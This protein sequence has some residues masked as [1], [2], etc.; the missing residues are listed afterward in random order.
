M[1]KPSQ[2]IL[3]AILEKT[4][5]LKISG[6]ASFNSSV[7]FKNIVT[8]LLARGYQHFVLDLADCLTM[9]STFLGVLAGIVLRMEEQSGPKP[10]LELLN[11]N[12]RIVD[13]LEN[14]GVGHLFKVLNE[15]NPCTNLFQPASSSQPAPSKVEISRT[16]LEAHQI[17][18]AVNPANIP[19]FKEVTQFLMEDLKAL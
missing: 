12:A 4:V 7:E 6:R 15:E 2:P 19:K 13:L 11:P 18:M 17:L 5:F 1:T 10:R 3:V 14:L 9:D 16:C 8:E